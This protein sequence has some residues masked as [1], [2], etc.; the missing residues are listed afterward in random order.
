MTASDSEATMKSDYF[1]WVESQERVALF[2]RLQVQRV[3]TPTLE[4]FL[5]KFFKKKG[6][7]ESFDDHIRGGKNLDKDKVLLLLLELTIRDC[8][9]ECR[10]SRAKYWKNR[11]L[12]KT[13]MER[14]EYTREVKEFKK[15]G[16]RLREELKKKYEDKVNHLKKKFGRKGETNMRQE[17]LDQLRCYKGVKILN[18]G[19]E[20]ELDDRESP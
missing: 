9:A 1:K 16:E 5:R 7:E 11:N 18:I 6:G 20:E 12:Q 13:I 10:K 3:G 4:H 8:Q 14:R 19:G 17:H 2:R 15:E